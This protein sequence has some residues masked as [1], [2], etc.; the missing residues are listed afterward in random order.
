CGEAFTVFDL[1]EQ[2]GLASRLLEQCPDLLLYQFLGGAEH[3]PEALLICRR[4]VVL[5]GKLIDQP[6]HVHELPI[7]ADR[8]SAWLAYLS[9]QFLPQTKSGQNR[10]AKPGR[11]R[12]VE[13]NVCPGCGRSVT[14]RP[15]EK[16]W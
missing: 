13:T 5:A 8:V 6:K 1:A 4:G 10:T 3:G 9:E 14:P 2:A 11:F 15:I 7:R 16:W 12:I